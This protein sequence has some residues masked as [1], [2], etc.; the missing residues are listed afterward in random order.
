MSDIFNWKILR[1]KQGIKIEIGIRFSNSYS[2]FHPDNFDMSK[3]KKA[4]EELIKK[5]E[6]KTENQ[7]DDQQ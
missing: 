5:L 6:E 1:K 4:V 2:N 3:T 7:I